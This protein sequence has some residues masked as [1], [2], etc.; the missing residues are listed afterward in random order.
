MLFVGYFFY[1]LITSSF[2][3]HSAPLNI[4]CMARLIQRGRF[5]WFFSFFLVVRL[6]WVFRARW[7]K[8]GDEE[9]KKGRVTERCQGKVKSTGN[10]CDWK[11]QGVLVVW[12]NVWRRQD[13]ELYHYRARLL[14]PIKELVNHL[15]IAYVFSLPQFSFILFFFFRL[16]QD[17]FFNKDLCIVEFLIT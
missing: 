15:C 1:F 8:T 6:G 10:E 5:Y 3:A 2:P 13:F 14:L 9:R 4:F 11:V 16:A 12:W 7:Q 17:C